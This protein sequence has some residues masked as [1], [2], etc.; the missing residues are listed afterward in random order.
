MRQFLITV[1]VATAA[2][3]ALSACEKNINTNPAEATI[4][5]ETQWGPLDGSKIIWGHKAEGSPGY[6][7]AAELSGYWSLF[8]SQVYLILHPD[9]V[10]MIGY[11]RCTEPSTAV[12][13]AKFDRIMNGAKE[14][15]VTNSDFNT[16]AR[17]AQERESEGMVVIMWYDE[18]SGLYHGVAYTREEW[19][20]LFGSG[21]E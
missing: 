18:H 16:V 4:T 13:K 17:W 3:V 21:G 19:N 10:N 6:G 14:I 15:H 9:S 1:A 12:I 5:A 11:I 20:R 7:L 8:G 2:L